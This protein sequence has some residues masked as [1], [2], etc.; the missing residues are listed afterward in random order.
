MANETFQ[1]LTEQ[2][3]LARF[4]AGAGFAF[5]GIGFT[6]K[7]RRLFQLA[8]IPIA[9]NIVLFI[10]MVWLGF[11]FYDTI[12]GWAAVDVSPS[13][14]S[15]WWA[16]FVQ[17]MAE[18]GA[19]LLRILVAILA[20][21]LIFVIGFVA[22]VTLGNI[23][24]G[25][26]FDMMSER[27]E[28]LVLGRSVAE[29]FTWAS[30]AQ[31]MGQELALTL[32]RLAIYLIGVVAIFVVGLVPG[33][34]SLIGSAA[35]SLWSWMFLAVELKNASLARHK[36]RGTE[37]VH[38]VFQHKATHLGFGAAS[39]LMMFVPITMPFLVVGATRHHL[40]LAAYG[41]A[42]SLLQDEDRQ[43]LAQLA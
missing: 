28:E 11:S 24:N 27:T 42:P 38:H 22:S 13:S 39:W 34:G 33:I 25:P 20:V 23:I 32:V 10:G 7:H 40:A 30:F 9:V 4:F 29:P 19:F 2:G 36:V 31:D 16:A 43:K 37:R 35:G 5:S 3:V 1:D 12:V 26:F 14:D 41:H 18:A 15:G 21:L 6:L 17:W 8:L